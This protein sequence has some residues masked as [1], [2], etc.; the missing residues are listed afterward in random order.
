LCQSGTLWV[1][2]SATRTCDTLSI[3]AKKEEK[4]EE[5]LVVSTWNAE[6]QRVNSREKEVEKNNTNSC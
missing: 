5:D 1:A 2:I 4:K 3:G 6:E